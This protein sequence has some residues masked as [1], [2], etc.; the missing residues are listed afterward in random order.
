MGALPEGAPELQLENPAARR[1]ASE[2][3]APQENPGCHATLMSAQYGATDQGPW[4]PWRPA[5]PATRVPE[6]GCDET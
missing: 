1:G 5:W 6:N 2:T 3:L 4:L